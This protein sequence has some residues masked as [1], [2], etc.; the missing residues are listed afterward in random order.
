MADL[1]QKPQIKSCDMTQE[2][3]DAATA[4]AQSVS[5]ARNVCV[6]GSGSCAE[7]ACRAV[8]HLLSVPY[9]VA[10]A[11]QVGPWDSEY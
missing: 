5:N 6:Y 10:T 9:A 1:K 2:M 11:P 7:S 8:L 4:S 3:Q